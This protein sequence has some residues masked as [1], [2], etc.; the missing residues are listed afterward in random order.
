ML[1]EAAATREKI[2]T[3]LGAVTTE[4]HFEKLHKT[5]LSDTCD[6]IFD[7]PTYKQWASSDFSLGKPQLLWIN[8]P[9]G[10]GKSFLCARIIQSMME[11][12]TST[13]AYFF[14]SSDI[15]TQREPL[16]IVRSWI[17]QLTRLSKDA[18]AI[19]YE[20]S[21][22]DETPL[23]SSSQ[24]WELFNSIVRVV[25]D[26]SLILDGLD[27]CT[28]MDI[29]NWRTAEENMR[30][31]FIV[32]LKASVEGTTTRILVVSR[33]VSDIRSGISSQMENAAT[34]AVYVCG[35]TQ[36]DVQ[37]DLAL[38]SRSI[39]DERLPKK[40]DALR[41]DIATQIADKSNGMF[42]WVKLQAK[43]LRI[44]KN[45]NQLRKAIQDMPAGLDRV[46][47]RDW[48]KIMNLKRSDRSRALAILLWVTFALRP[49]TVAELIEALLITD[50]GRSCDDLQL[51]E[52]PDS[53]D[54]DYI[55]DQILDLCGSMLEVKKTNENQSFDSMTVHLV[56]FSVKE[57]LLRE[58][59]KTKSFII[60]GAASPNQIFQN[61]YLA[62]NCL[63]YLLYDKTWLCSSSSSCNQ[64]CRPFLEY[65]VSSWY[66]HIS[67]E[68]DMEK[69]LSAVI[70][71]FFD[72]K[73]QNWHFWRT[74]FERKRE[75]T[76]ETKEEY[77]AAS[78]F[79]YAS[80]FGFTHTVKFLQEHGSAEIDA[81][82]GE[83]GSALQAASFHGHLSIVQ[84][85]CSR[86]ADF[87][88]RGGKYGTALNAAAHMG[89]AK[90]VETLLD[91]KADISITDLEGRTPVYLASREGNL[92]VLK[93]LLEKVPN[94][95]N[96]SSFYG[97]TL[98]TIAATKGHFEVVKY[99]VEKG[100]DITLA[101]SAEWTPLNLAAGSGHFE[102]LKYLVEKGADITIANSKGWT[103]LYSAAANG[104]LEVVKYLVDNG[105]DVNSRLLNGTTSL[106]LA[107]EAGHDA[108]VKLLI[109]KGADV[110][111]KN[112]NDRTALSWAAQN[113]HEAVVKLLLEQSSINVESKDAEYNST[114]LS[115]AAQNGHEAVVKLLIENG[116]DFKARNNNGVSPFTRAAAYGHETIMK[117]L[118]EQHIDVNVKD[119]KWG[120]TPLS[121]VAEWGQEVTAKV[122]LEN[123]AD[124][125][126]QDH[127]GVTALSFAAENGYEGIVK[128][129]LEKGADRECKDNDGLTAL[130]WAAANGH[131]AI[132]KLL[133]ERSITVP[134]AESFELSAAL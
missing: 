83:H 80:F 74:H 102:I 77:A 48:E 6:W 112:K 12:Q 40:D 68:N 87:N 73:N 3:W 41:E 134:G 29:K 56:H 10:F 89:H 36:D 76:T 127:I 17:L 65:A 64:K 54:Q 50:G 59:P 100:A 78:P 86:G 58:L 132:V 105:A 45:R 14:C 31:D 62:K 34:Q 15:E 63:W 79:Y 28:Q 110:N 4:Q 26:S 93:L 44:G 109:E 46:Y 119:V 55:D 24:I 60:E 71:E 97:W 107:A 13:V 20:K 103:P 22:L 75:P 18:F 49:L 131:E 47:D 124:L 16:A 120:Q 123:G 43:N 90:I 128:L 66:L 88:L 84:F 115:W 30:H 19:V 8:A 5:R 126:S 113:G 32:K 69:E 82:G 92:E 42:L 27:E 39:V 104:H 72:P 111:S 114:P 67:L 33:N 117:L 61:N 106:S 57:F 125:D 2:R 52:W 116:A 95:I 121:W 51:D 122:L 21:C 129:L 108:I 1:I 99:L 35:L 23:A 7:N 96:A 91:F 81:V 9:A 94:D 130:S 38:F 85:L 118:L 70:N 98:L 37:S 11:A 25:P 101:R 133:E 53:I